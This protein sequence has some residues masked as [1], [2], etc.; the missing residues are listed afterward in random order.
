[1]LPFKRSKNQGRNHGG[2]FL[3]KVRI[4]SNMYYIVFNG[5]L[6]GNSE[7]QKTI[8]KHFQQLLVLLLKIT[9]NNSHILVFTESSAPSW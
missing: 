3:G 6:G 4:G 8:Q 9:L 1:M 5:S 7:L 2:V